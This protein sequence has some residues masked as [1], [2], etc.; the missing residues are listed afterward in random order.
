MLLLLQLLWWLLL[1]LLRLQ[2][3]LSLDLKPRSLDSL[4]LQSL[5]HK[6]LQ[7]IPMITI[8]PGLQKRCP[9]Y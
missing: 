1:W 7:D 8:R 5:Q 2:A 9:V 4:L 3:P 6:Q